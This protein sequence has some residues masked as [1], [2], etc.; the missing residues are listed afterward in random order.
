MVAYYDAIIMAIIGS[1]LSGV[2]LSVVT[3]LGFQ[4]GLF[5]GALVATI[6]LYDAMFRNPPIATRSP[7]VAVSVVGWHAVLVALAFVVIGG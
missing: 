4:T 2:A 7:P 1:V 5:L 6:F 3:S